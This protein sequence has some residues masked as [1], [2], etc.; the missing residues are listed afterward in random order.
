MHSLEQRLKEW[1]FR[2]CSNMWPNY[3]NM[4]IYISKLDK[5]DEAKKCMLT[6]NRYRC[7]LRDAARSCQIQSWV[8]AS[9]HWNEN[10]TPVG[11]I[12]ER[13]ERVD[14][15]WNPMRT[16]MSTNQSSQGLKYYTK[17]LHG[18]THGSSCICIRGWPYWPPMEGEALGPAKFEPPM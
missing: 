5:I 7:L 12:S 3:I 16:T 18:L 14:G 17:N 15:D 13:I 4:C 9:N 11:A 1:P 6:G 10:R 2:D 8:L